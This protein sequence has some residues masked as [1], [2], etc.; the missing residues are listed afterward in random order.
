[1]RTR[2][3][4]ALIAVISIV[5]IFYFWRARG[6]YFVTAVATLGSIFEYSRLT[7]QR[8]GVNALL[9]I[10]FFVLTFALFLAVIL[11]QGLALAILAIGAIAMLTMSLWQVRENHDLRTTL[12]IQSA[13]LVG[14]LYCGLF[15]ALAACTLRFPKGSI[16][17]FGL[18]AIVFSGD[19]LA[20]LAGRSFGKTKLLVDV[21][22]KKTIEGSIGGLIGSGLAG[23]L[24][25]LIFIQETPWYWVGGAALVTGAFA[26][27]G[28][29]FESLLKRLADVKDSGSIMPGHGG[30]LDRIDGVLFAAP[31]YYILVRFITQLS[32]HS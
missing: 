32:M 19:T 9:R 13:A 22:P 20:Y 14:L 23:S 8:A 15:P 25:A 12:Q 21:S 29:L 10:S 7:F 18:L 2:V 6:L 24:L 5:A 3:V 11:D 31:V 1:M 16:W 30:F 4:S 27:A 17:Y 28:D 26:Q